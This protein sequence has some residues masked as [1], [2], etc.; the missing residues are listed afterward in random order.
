MVISSNALFHF[1]KTKEDLLDIL[2]NGFRARYCL[3]NLS[4]LFSTEDDERWQ[5][6]FPMIC[7]CDL[8]LSQLREHVN[9]YGRYG[10]GMTKEWGIANGINPVLY[11]HPRSDLAKAVADRVKS[12]LKN[13]DDGLAGLYI[14]L[15]NYIKLYDGY[16]RRNGEKHYKRFY[17]EKEWRWVPPPYP[18]KKMDGYSLSKADYLNPEFKKAADRGLADLAKPLFTAKDIKYIIVATEEE[19]LSVI[20][21]IEAIQGSYSPDH[22]KLMAS[23]LISVEHILADF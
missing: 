14:E 15:L 1:T 12:I 5:V 9:F 10:I 20:R 13:E 23:K 19:I 16:V 4:E 11:L 21:E 2:V 18:L 6:A 3:E 22:L 8:P 7:F 17:D